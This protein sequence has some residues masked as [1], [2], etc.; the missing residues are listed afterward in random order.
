[1]AGLRRKKGGKAGF[2]NPYC[3]PSVMPDLDIF[4]DY[5]LCKAEH[6]FL[7]S[8]KPKLEIPYDYSSYGKNYYIFE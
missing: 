2:E 6:C 4:R 5:L 3:G 7:R 1:M 8:R